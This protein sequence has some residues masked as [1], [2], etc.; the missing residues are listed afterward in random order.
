MG[1]DDGLKSGDSLTNTEVGVARDYVESV[2]LT[3]VAEGDSVFGTITSELAIFETNTTWEETQ[4]ELKKKYESDSS[5]SFEGVR[6]ESISLMNWLI[7]IDPEESQSYV[8]DVIL[9]RGKE[10]SRIQSE[11]LIIDIAKDL[12]AESR[13]L[14]LAYYAWKGYLDK[15]VLSRFKPL[16][17]RVSDKLDELPNRE[18]V[19]YHL[20]KRLEYVAVLTDEERVNYI[21]SLSDKYGG[22]V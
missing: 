13:D 22:I 7:N 15:S 21:Q 19:R 6:S 20:L 17:K 12:G 9:R 11:L 3:A 1:K 10:N 16:I 4:V 5:L 2:I 14:S 18:D 8:R